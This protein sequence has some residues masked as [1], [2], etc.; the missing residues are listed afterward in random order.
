MYMSLCCIH[1]LTYTMSIISTRHGFDW[2]GIEPHT[3]E[4]AH[5]W[6]R[7]RHAHFPDIHHRHSHP[8]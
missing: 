1:M 7:H 3:H 4:H 6:L 5:G 8:H 2:D